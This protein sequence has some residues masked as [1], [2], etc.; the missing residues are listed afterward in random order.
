MNRLGL[1]LS[2]ALA[3]S[4]DVDAFNLKSCDADNP[5]AGA[6][7]VLED[8]TCEAHSFFGDRNIAMYTQIDDEAEFRVIGVWVDGPAHL[9]PP[10]RYEVAVFTSYDGLQVKCLRPLGPPVG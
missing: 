1:L 6:V 10:G 3:A 7:R 9:P 2:L 4:C 5:P 8:Y